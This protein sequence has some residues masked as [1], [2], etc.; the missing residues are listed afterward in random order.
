M[1]IDPMAPAWQPHEAATIAEFSA[2]HCS[3]GLALGLQLT[4]GTEPFR[5]MVTA[6]GA[7]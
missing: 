3:V 5:R 1:P 2:A 4:W 7:R 6:L